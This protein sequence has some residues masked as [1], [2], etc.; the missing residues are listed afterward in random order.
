MESGLRYVATQLGLACLASSLSP[1]EGL[2]VF[3][4]LQKA[5]KCFVL[6]N[7]LHIIYQVVPIYAAVGWPNL[8]WMNFLTLWESL[9]PDMKRVGELVGVEE[10]FLV[11]AMRGTV[12]VQSQARL[13]AIH[14]R[15]Y[16]ALALN[17]LVNEV[18]LSLVSQKYGASKGMLQSLQ[19]AASTFAGM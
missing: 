9:S 2:K 14:Q 11:R 6:E 13:L 3:E 1:D 8:D 7:E 18:P 19:Q 15:F 10:R 16:T 17:D 5:R 12:N 4:E